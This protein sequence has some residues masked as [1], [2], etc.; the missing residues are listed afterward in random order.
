MSSAVTVSHTCQ[1]GQWQLVSSS[2]LFF[3][4][5]GINLILPKRHS[6]SYVKAAEGEHEVWKD[7]KSL[8][9]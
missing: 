5:S 9:S 7:N 2:V 3:F 6:Q 4:V 1:R 8:D